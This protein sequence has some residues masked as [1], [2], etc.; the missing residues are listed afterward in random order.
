[1]N[2]QMY[3]ETFNAVNIS[4]EINILWDLKY[5]GNISD[6]HSIKS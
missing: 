4:Q 5:A 3:Y 6:Q 1:M 2:I